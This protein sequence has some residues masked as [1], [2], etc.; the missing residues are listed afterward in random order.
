M[1]QI[2]RN[3]LQHRYEMGDR[4]FSYLD[5]SGLNLE[6]MNLKGANLQGSNLKGTNLENANLKGT[7]LINCNCYRV[8]LYKANLSDI[9]LSYANLKEGNCHR[10]RIENACLDYVCLERTDFS[11]AYVK[12]VSVRCARFYKTDLTDA[13]LIDVNLTQ[14]Y[15]SEIYYSKLTRLTNCFKT[16]KSDLFEFLNKYSMQHDNGMDTTLDELQLNFF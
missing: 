8:N 3:Q 11:E 1:F 2:K 16:E 4:D 7:N 6:N 14:A 15:V 5:L 12:T 9:D 13:T 10:T